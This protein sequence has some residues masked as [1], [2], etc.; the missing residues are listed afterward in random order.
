VAALL[1]WNLAV[2]DSWSLRGLK[3][4]PKLPYRALVVSITPKLIAETFRML[5]LERRGFSTRVHLVYYAF[6]AFSRANHDSG[7]SSIFLRISL[8][9][10]GRHS[11]YQR[12]LACIIIAATLNLLMAV[13]PLV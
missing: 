2:R 11:S 4:L 8:Q 9:P 5:R 6:H 7:T 1:F 3:L 10:S 12:M 13:L